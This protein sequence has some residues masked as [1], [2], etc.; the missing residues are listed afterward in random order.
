[1]GADK[2][3]VNRT[4]RRGGRLRQIIAMLLLGLVLGIVAG[5]NDKPTDNNKPVKITDGTAYFPMHDGDIWYYNSFNTIIRVE[6]DT[7]VNGFACKRVFLGNEVDQAW[8][9]TQQRF[10]QHLIAGCWW[11]DPPL[12][13]PLDLEKGKAYSFSSLGRVLE[14]CESDADSMRSI[15]TLTFDGYVSEEVNNTTVDSCLKLDYDYVTTVYYKDG[16]TESIPSEYFELWGKEIGLIYNGD[17]FL[18]LAIIDGD[19]IPKQPQ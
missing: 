4:S 8:S 13:I 9:L 11:F 16:R 1:M 2:N 3:R 12:D 17:I 18:D 14:T 10:A 7:A 15:G 6:G 19:T 5:C